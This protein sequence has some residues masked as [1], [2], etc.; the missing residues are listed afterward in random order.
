M[1]I[2]GR[3][4]M[5]T[6]HFLVPTPLPMSTS[7]EPLNTDQITAREVQKIQQANRTRA[8]TRLDAPS[9]PL[10]YSEL[11]IILTD[12]FPALSFAFEA[13]LSAIG[14]LL[15]H[16]VG[17]CI[18]ILLV[19]AASSGKTIAL[20]VLMG[21]PELVYPTDYLTAAAFISNSSNVK[22]ADLKGI[23]LLPKIKNKAL[24]C[25]DLAPIFASREDDLTKT[26]GILTRLLDGEG[27]QTNTG[28][29]GQRSY[30]G[31]FRFV[32]LGATTPIE[33]RVWRVMSRLGPRILFLRL[34]SRE[35]SESELT[36]QLYEESYRFKI[37]RCKQATNRFLRTL[38]GKHSTGVNWIQDENSMEC[39]R[40]ISRCAKLLCR[41]RGLVADDAEEWG[42]AGRRRRT[43]NVRVQA[44]ER[45][46]RINQ[47]LYDISRGHAL[48]TGRTSITM[49]D[50]PLV[51]RLTFD[52]A[53]EHRWNIM[54]ALIEGGGE[55]GTSQIEDGLDC[56]NPTALKAMSTLCAL[57]ICERVVHTKKIEDARIRV[58]P[59]FEWFLGDECK[60]MLVRAGLL[61]DEQ[62]GISKQP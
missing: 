55:L 39:L 40:I 22:K 5:C 12:G 31:D 34:H 44:I 2:S 56:S 24:V 61:P 41:L 1:E 47:A 25:R 30:V 14:T 6:A 13:E 35:K 33:R 26:I 51:L 16:D 28:V 62:E 27:Y 11:H 9:D 57:G 23:D 54:R 21:C 52:S 8:I 42:E 10:S 20:D 17:S 3:G 58:R 15:I 36:S 32:F 60:D 37:D 7:S 43:I 4:R 49:D 48:I 38:W 19:D 45:P 29:H 59:D 46:D 50:I 18:A 53:P